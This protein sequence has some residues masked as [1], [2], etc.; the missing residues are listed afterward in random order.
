MSETPDPLKPTD[1]PDQ[2]GGG[3]NGPQPETP[4][5]STQGITADPPDG[6]SGGGSGTAQ[7]QGNS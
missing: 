1:P 7:T 5:S 6:Q 4:E 3:G 2:Q